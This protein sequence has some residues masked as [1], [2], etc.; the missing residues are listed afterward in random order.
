[1]GLPG[2]FLMLTGE[3]SE[4]VILLMLICG[5]PL[6][7]LQPTLPKYSHV[8]SVTNLWSRFVTISGW[9]QSA[10]KS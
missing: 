4:A 7:G 6:A 5:M 10:G 2:D 3:V 9:A 1:M 8:P